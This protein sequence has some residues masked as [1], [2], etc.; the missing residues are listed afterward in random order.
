MSRGTDT[1]NTLNRLYK[2]IE[3]KTRSLWHDL[4]YSQS[5]KAGA[6]FAMTC[7]E[8][9]KY[10]DLGLSKSSLRQKIRYRLHISICQIC[11]NY[12]ELTQ[13]LKTKI[14]RIQKEQKQ[15]TNRE[16]EEM[17]KNLFNQ[18]ITKK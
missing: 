2:Q 12:A 13:V 8:A 3:R 9:S 15:L 6:E 10:T 5:G 16:V 11:K 4:Y 1:V 14:K 17:N 7:E 18:I